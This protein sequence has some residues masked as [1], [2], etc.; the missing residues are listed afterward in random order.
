M[1][2]S[3]NELFA[4][5]V[6]DADGGQPFARLHA[7]KNC[8]R[9]QFF[10]ARLCHQTSSGS[11]R[12]ASRRGPECASRIP[13]PSRTRYRRGPSCRRSPCRTGGQPLSIVDN[14]QNAPIAFRDFNLRRSAGAVIRPRTLQHS[15][16]YPSVCLLLRDKR[17][18]VTN[19]IGT[20]DGNK[21]DTRRSYR[22]CRIW[23][24]ALGR[25]RWK[26]LP[27]EG[28]PGLIKSL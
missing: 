3:Q 1:F 23:H 18:F 5:D 10:D 16:Y 8:G 17:L 26:H 27:N 25:H 6:G 4:R 15:S 14:A 13:F 24:K 2:P 7:A 19:G 21:D 28:R 12:L 20:I 9:H 22:G 11:R